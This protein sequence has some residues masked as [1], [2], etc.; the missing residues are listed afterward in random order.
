MKQLVN[1]D[2]YLLSDKVLCVAA[3]IWISVEDELPD[4]SRKVLITDGVNISCAHWFRHRYK[5]DH[6]KPEEEWED[7]GPAWVNQHE[8]LTGD[9]IEEPG[10][11]MDIKYLLLLP[12]CGERAT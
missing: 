5:P 2:P 1:I 8:R 6:T 3:P 4:D 7:K 10:W 12:T 11:W 9:F